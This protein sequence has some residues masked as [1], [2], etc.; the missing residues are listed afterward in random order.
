[1]RCGWLSLC[2][3]LMVG[4][5]WLQAQSNQTGV[6]VS[7]ES[8]ARQSDVLRIEIPVFE[9]DL[10]FSVF[11]LSELGVL[12]VMNQNALPG[13]GAAVASGA[14]SVSGSRSEARSKS[15]S[16]SLDFYDENLQRRW[17]SDVVI[18]GEYQY[19]GFRQGCDSLY[20]ALSCL[21]H[22][23]SER[24]LA[25]L[26]V[27]ISDGAWRL[28]YLPVEIS[29]HTEILSLKMGEDG[30]GFLA[31]EKGDYVWYYVGMNTGLDEAT[32]GGGEAA[33]AAGAASADA[34]GSVHTA[35]GNT[36]SAEFALAPK[37]TPLDLGRAAEWCH[38]ATDTARQKI[39]ALFRDEKL[40]QNGLM[41]R[42][43]DW[44]GGGLS[45]FDLLPSDE[46]LRL[47]DGQMTVLP[48]GQLWVGGT[49]HLSRERQTTSNYDRGTETTG[50]YAALYQSK[51]DE[52]GFTCQ[53]LNFWKQAYY[54]FP[55]L[56]KYMSREAWYN[57]QRTQEKSKGR[58]VIPGFTTR[59]RTG[60][61][62]ATAGAAASPTLY[63]LGEVY[64]RIESSTTEMFYDAYGRMMP[65]TRTFFEGFRFRDG[66]LARFDSQG[67]PLNQSV[68][69]LDRN[70]LYSQLSDY[71]QWVADSI[72]VMLYAHPI[73]HQL[74]YRAL[75]SV[76]DPAEDVAMFQLPSLYESD[77]VQKSWGGALTPWYNH[78]FLVYGYQQIRNNRLGNQRRNVFY[79]Q[80]IVVE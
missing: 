38:L 76:Y 18:G 54:D 43:F 57:L 36:A 69:D 1:M 31:K 29:T 48:N 22:H 66:F 62:A 27:C 45:K 77:K 80:K 9:D 32:A 65:Y 25:R 14:G 44:Q 51:A 52:S 46:G 59:V 50:L 39:F 12:V 55:D 30:W 26:A 6:A 15:G 3:S 70:H 19:V 8:A 47:T 13:S 21:P 72:G 49:Y 34:T 63:V 68:F 24:P 61:E 60:V 16:R 58:T 23:A 17:H 35:A 4:T 33:S 5:G 75:G 41:L 28:D 71:S 73:D 78:T 42:I 10:P 2:L 37:R 11:P 20:F 40:R 7:R 67:R 53:R 64:T 79:L 74:A 56:Q